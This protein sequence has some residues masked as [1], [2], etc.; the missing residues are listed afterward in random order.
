MISEPVQNFRKFFLFDLSF[1]L[2]PL[3]FTGMICGIV[4]SAQL[5]LIQDVQP[6]IWLVPDFG[7]NL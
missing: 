5:R 7:T 1:P 4:P 3:A 6:L 2:F